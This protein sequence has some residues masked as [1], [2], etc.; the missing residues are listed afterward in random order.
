MSLLK[1]P[2]LFILSEFD[3]EV[4]KLN[5][6]VF[7]KILCEK[8]FETISGATHLF[9]EPGRLEKVATSATLWFSKFLV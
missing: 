9:E 4:I 5:K 1:I 2:S 6:E 3:E 8:K 7:D